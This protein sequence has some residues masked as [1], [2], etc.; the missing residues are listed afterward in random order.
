MKKLRRA[1]ASAWLLLSALGLAGGAAARD[2][3]DRPECQD[4]GDLVCSEEARAPLLALYDLPTIESRQAEGS[5]LYRVFISDAWRRHHVAI[6]V[7]YGSGS[8]PTLTLH[9]PMRPARPGA[10]A[11]AIPAYAVPI[12]LRDWYRVGRLGR[13]FHRTLVP[14][15]V[16]PDVILVCTGHG[17]T[18]RVESAD[19]G[20]GDEGRGVRRSDRH[21][22]SQEGLAEP[23][24]IELTLLAREL[25]P[26]CAALDEDA[27]RF[28]AELL[29][30]CA[31]LSG[32]RLAAAEAYNHMRL[33]LVRDWEPPSLDQLDDLLGRANV[34]VP[35]RAQGMSPAQAWLQALTGEGDSELVV[36]RVHAGTSNDIRVDGLFRRRVRTGRD[37]EPFRVQEATVQLH[38]IRNEFHDLELSRLTI[39]AY[40]PV[41]DRCYAGGSPR[42]ARTADC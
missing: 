42:L 9:A 38:W 6:T 13:L 30:A 2:V 29:R 19:G 24:G 17:P 28:T 41:P 34:D 35:D 4:M 37:D 23:F 12:S 36:E 32:D 10:P 26:A 40:Q 25:L 8:D 33:L 31:I 20:Q 15:P 1:A 22:C 3:P 5:D 7:E 18:Y 39:G 14:E 11:E 16:D 27:F 21:L